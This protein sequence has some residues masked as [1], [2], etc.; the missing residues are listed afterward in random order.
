MAA[1]L[2]QGMR[3]LMVLAVIACG[4]TTEEIRTARSATYELD[5][6]QLLQIALDVTKESYPI[7]YVN[8]ED[9]TVAT[10]PRFYSKEGDLESEGAGGWAQVVPGSVEVTWIVTI[11][12][13]NDSHRMSNII[14]VPKTFQLVSGS[15]KPREL[16][17]DDP[18]LPPWILGRADSLQIAIYQRAKAYAR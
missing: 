13:T 17:T 9:V 16:S 10:R 15:P 7:G 12:P 3:T 8:Q 11:V 14:V 6:H 5:P 1:V 18:Y 2:S 4:P